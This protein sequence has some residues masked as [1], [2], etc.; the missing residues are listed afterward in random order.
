MVVKKAICRGNAAKKTTMC[1]FVQEKC[2]SSAMSLRVPNTTI[3]HQERNRNNEEPNMTAKSLSVVD[4]AIALVL[5][6]T[7]TLIDQ[8]N[9]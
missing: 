3:R 7:G 2:L 8:R 6:Y 4:L 1:V 5:A 9:R